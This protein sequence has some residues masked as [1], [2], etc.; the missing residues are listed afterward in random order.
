MLDGS[1]TGSDTE[2]SHT[3]LQHRSVFAEANARLSRNSL[4]EVLQTRGRTLRARVT[5]KWNPG[6][7][8]DGASVRH[9]GLRRHRLCLPQRGGS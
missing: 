4:N 3:M 7:G 2:A 9:G 5:N 8:T 6:V 1:A